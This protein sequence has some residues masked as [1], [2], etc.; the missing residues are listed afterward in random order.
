M[1]PSNRMAP[2]NWKIDQLVM[3]SCFVHL[4]D[5]KLHPNCGQ[6][7]RIVR[8]AKSDKENMLVETDSDE[9]SGRSSFLILPREMFL[10]VPEFVCEEYS[11]RAGHLAWR[12]N[13]QGRKLFSDMNWPSTAATFGQAA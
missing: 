4:A 8:L 6:I 1:S 3:L 2:E 11:L 9:S 5:K 12:V 10:P 7:C 13:E